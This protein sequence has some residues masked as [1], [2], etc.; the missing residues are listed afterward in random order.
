MGGPPGESLDGQVGGRAVA[1]A[2]GQTSGQTPLGKRTGSCK[3]N[4][5]CWRFSW[6]T[7]CGR[8]GERV[9]FGFW[10]VLCCFVILQRGASVRTGHSFCSRRCNLL[11]YLIEFQLDD[12]IMSYTKRY[13]SIK[14][15]KIILCNNIKY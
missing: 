5:C 13:K 15:E 12:L 3:K 11:V 9:F 4:C 6:W 14:Y 1:R 10:S 2:G 7:C 8:D